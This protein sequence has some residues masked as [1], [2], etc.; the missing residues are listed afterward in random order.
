MSDRISRRTV[1]AAAAG[2][3]TVA[4]LGDANV[5]GARHRDRRS[6]RVADAF[7]RALQAKDIDAFAALWTDDAV[8][9]APIT[10]EGGPGEIVGRDAIM[11]NLRGAFEVFGDV[12]FTWEV[13]PLLD[14]RH[15]LATWTLDIELLTGGRY[16]NRGVAI[17]RLRGER[18]AHFAEHFDTI[19]WQ[20]AFGGGDE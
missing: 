18:I 1:L 4:V 15:A 5:A 8:W 3:S 7:Y 20:A 6:V 16:I 12:Q 2:G 14:P 19:A 10:V 17:F 9:W 13:E 11:A